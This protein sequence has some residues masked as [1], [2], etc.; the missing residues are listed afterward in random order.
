MPQVRVKFSPGADTHG[1]SGRPY[2][3]PASLTRHGLSKIVAQLGQQAEGLAQRRFIGA[4]GSSGAGLSMGGGKDGWGWNNVGEF[5]FFAVLPGGA[6]NAQRV[7]LGSSTLGDFLADN[8]LSSEVV[9]TLE[10]HSA[11]APPTAVTGAMKVIGGPRFPAWVSSVAASRT[12][13]IATGDTALVAAGCSDGSLH[14][15]DCEGV[16]RVSTPAHALGIQGIAVA[17]SGHNGARVITASKDSTLQMWEM[18]SSPGSPPGPERSLKLC[19]K[20]TLRGHDGGVEAVATNLRHLGDPGAQVKV[21]VCSGSRDKT[22]RLWTFENEERKTSAICGKR[23]RRGDAVAYDVG[24]EDIFPVATLSGHT[25]SVVAV[26]WA[27]ASVIYS[28]SLDHSIRSWD[29]VRSRQISMLNGPKVV[30]S[31]AFSGKLR[32]L[33]SGH[34]DHTIRLWDARAAGDSV[35]KTELQSHKAWVSAVGWSC[36]HEFL[37]LS[38]SYDHSVKVWDVRTTTPLH[39][40]SMSPRPHAKKHSFA[41]DDFH[42]TKILCMDVCSSRLREGRDSVFTGGADSALYALSH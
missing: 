42:A 39:S 13:A 35:V 29:V 19:K 28:G 12:L 4:A 8:G 26:A 34:S 36:N 27:D 20:T 2:A 10:Y 15:C 33:A 31:I 6:R 22:L 25:D 14:L 16:P 37:L 30:T 7:L 9:I 5:E 3:V 17:R 11:R 40:I 38:A 1:I 32:L 21:I 41:R 23:R 24:H 18:V